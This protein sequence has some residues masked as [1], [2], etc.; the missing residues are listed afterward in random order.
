MSDLIEKLET[1]H[2]KGHDAKSQNAAMIYE[3]KFRELCW[4]SAPEILSALKTVRGN[5]GT[6]ER[7]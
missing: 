2:Q 7:E 4:A 5:R 3:G 6:G 1:Y